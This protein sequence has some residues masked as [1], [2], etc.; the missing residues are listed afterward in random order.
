MSSCR[1]CQ[2]HFPSNIKQPII[3]KPNPTHPF[4]EITAD[5]CVHAG[6][7]LIII[8][9]YLDWPT[10]IPMGNNITPSHLIT[11][12]T[13]LFD[14]TAVPVVFWSDGGP[15]FTANQFQCFAEKWG[16]IQHTASPY[17]TLSNGKA[18]SDVKSMKKI[19]RTAWTG[20]NL[21]EEN[22]VEPCCSIIT[23]HQ[24]S[25]GYH[26]HNS[27]MNAQSKTCS[28]L[29]TGHLILSGS[30]EEAE[31]QE[32]FTRDVVRKHYNATACHLPNI[33]VG[34]NVAVQNPRMHLWDTYEI[35]TSIG[36]YC[37]YHIQTR[38]DQKSIRNCHSYAEELLLQFLKEHQAPGSQVAVKTQQVYHNQSNYHH[39]YH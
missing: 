17:Y 18:E 26:P 2:D 16:F 22:S 31:K 21:D 8:D 7:N 33:Q 38:K 15:Q 36:P 3:I 14:Q 34:Y 27:Y 12:L 6:K 25:V 19:I 28:Q 29:T 5:F 37:Q 30:I 11:A 1:Q 23:P 10:I 20:R 39:H 13:T 32:K 24:G 4:Q 35:V 9:C